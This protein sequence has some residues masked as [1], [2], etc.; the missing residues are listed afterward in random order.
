[1]RTISPVFLASLGLCTALLG[2]G[3]QSRTPVGQQTAPATPVVAS[4]AV[5]A[6][7]ASSPLPER[8]D[9]P[10]PHLTPRAQAETLY[11]VLL[12]EIL[13]ASG[14]LTDSYELLMRAGQT[15]NSPQ[16]FQR[17]TE[18]AFMAQ[19]G[20]RALRST[21]AWQQAHPQS[22]EAN[23]AVLQVLLA[24]NQI[25][26]TEWHLQQE[27][28]Q[29]SDAEMAENLYAI[30]LLYQRATNR[31]QVLHTVT[32]AL[33]EWLQ[34]DS[35]WYADALAVLGRL[36]LQTQ[37]GDTAHALMQQGT[38]H[39][40][41][42]SGVAFLALELMSQ[43]D[44]AAEP[45]VQAY[46]RRDDAL[47]P[48]L[49][50]YSR[51]LLAEQ[52]HPQ[53]LQ[54]L[55]QL[56]RR[57]PDQ[58]DTWLGLAALQTHTRQHTQAEASLQQFERLIEALPD[59]PL[60][61]QAR[62][63]AALLHAQIAQQQ[64]QYDKALE[65]LERVDDPQQFFSIQVQRASLLA[66]QGKLTQARQL[67]QQLPAFDP[68][69]RALKVRAEVQLLRDSGLY[70]EAFTLHQTLVDSHADDDEVLYEQALLAERTG[71]WDTMERLLRQVIARSPDFHHAKNALG[72]SL[73]DRGIRLREA[74][75]LLE[76]A[77]ALA[78][79]DPFITDSLGWLEYRSGNL[80]RAQEL[81][82][83]AFDAQPD[84]EIAAHLGEV[85]WKLG[86]PQQ[87]RSIWQQGLQ[88]DA[89]SRTLKETIQRL[90]RHGT[91]LR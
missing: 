72:Y 33:K 16:L 54:V 6:L 80:G 18:I 68:R 17:A 35:P 58:P 26:Q 37:D 42:S 13:A 53:A 82:A 91:P 7:A 8:T 28:S 75:E 47:P 88:L 86:Q 89:D 74:R 10:P 1:M 66:R 14:E 90:D 9:T 65:W 50:A 46:A 20:N 25:D 22:R 59:S 77:I 40:P 21:Q 63:E 71:Q 81:L 83:Q 61:D 69:T 85:L 73:A 67:L 23:K 32:A 56:T 57:Q 84:A 62:N 64:Q 41:A 70:Q 76:Q 39:N 29:S 31:A 15:R 49:M 38:A 52:D 78:P 11:E 79:G 43:G 51:L 87:A 24:L 48:F 3:C 4:P 45:V 2:S 34:P 27:L 55:E 12:A 36:H 60:Q 44:A 30:P 19:D 5:P